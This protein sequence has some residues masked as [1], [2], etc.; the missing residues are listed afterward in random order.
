MKTPLRVLVPFAVLVLIAIACT[1]YVVRPA[2]TSDHQDSPLTVD[3]PGAD[4]TDVFV[5]PA[6]DPNNVAL[7][8][9]VHPLI[10]AGQ[11]AEAAFDPGVMYQ[12]KI[13]TGNGYKEDKVVQFRAVGNG[14]AQQIE[15]YGPARPAAPG[16]RSRWQ[17]TPQSFRLNSKARLRDGVLAFAGAR[18]D[19]FYFDLAQF[20]DRAGSQLQVPSAVRERRSAGVGSVFS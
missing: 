11:S 20:L 6:A 16:V 4:I 17:G 12:F 13:A 10:P 5:F 1:L 15:M 9:D 18:Q 19:P 8:M 3:R 7:A 14:R 2:R